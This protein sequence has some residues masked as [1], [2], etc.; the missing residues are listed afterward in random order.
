MRYAV[1]IGLVVVLGSLAAIKWSQITT[2][3]AFA[4]DADRAGPPPEAVAAT[5]AT[6]EVWQETIRAVGTVASNE[7]VTISNEVPGVVERVAFE[8]GARVREGDVLVVLDAR[9]ERAELATA[10]AAAELAESTAARTRHLARQGAVAADVLDRAE[11][12]REAANAR[13]AMLRAQVAKK[14]LRAPFSG[15]LGIRSVNPGQYL[16]PG[17][18]VTELGSSEEM[19]VDFTLSQEELSEV[20]VGMPVRVRLEG[21]ISVEGAIAA[22]APNVSAS[23][24][25]GRLRAAVE[26][27]ED[28]LRAG[29]FVDVEIVLSDRSEVVAVPATAIVHAPYGDSVYVVQDRDPAAPGPRETPQGEPIWTARQQFV[30]TGERRGDFIEIERGLEPGQRVVSAGAFKLRNGS[31]IYLTAI[32]QPPT[33][34][35][36]AKPENR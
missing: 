22:L 3:I 35:L 32:G 34:E 25:A 36:D 31:P 2:L 19:F 18:T 6:S 14:T 11:A 8:S 5:D 23:T 24:R 17:T 4:Q 12:E 20:A 16:A 26:D 10:V 33:P 1:V 13:V 29:M 27:G 28:R 15:R 9:L 30:R 21:S 7:Q